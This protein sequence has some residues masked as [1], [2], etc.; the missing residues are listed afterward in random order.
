M[1]LKKR[2]VAGSTIE[3]QKTISTRYGITATRRE[4]TDRTPEAVQKYN[5][6]MARRQLIRIINAGFASGDI[7]LTLTYRRGERPREDEA[8]KD[9]SRLLRRL[10]GK[11]KKRGGELKYIAV[12]AIGSK[13]GIHHHLVLGG[14]VAED[15]RGLWDKGRTDIQYL[16][17]DGHYE[18]LATYL[19]DQEA[20]GPG[21]QGGIIGRRWSGSRNLIIPEP[22]IE[23]VDADT[24]REPPEAEIGYVIDVASIEAG[25]SPVSGQPYLYYRMLRADDK[26]ITQDGR[27]LKGRAA[28]KYQKV[29]NK[30]EIRR[31]MRKRYDAGTIQ[32]LRRKQRKVKKPRG[33][34]KGMEKPPSRGGVRAID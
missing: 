25:T 6:K 15:L 23:V 9:R 5:G 33:P 17:E 8:V 31:E 27:V 20:R 7:Y 28:H 32:V 12:T 21:G 10:R 2:Y 22:E 14:I 34:D 29:E 18:A 3:I 11:V 16:Y 24:W 13:G 4:K 1:Y 26:V 19:I 30:E